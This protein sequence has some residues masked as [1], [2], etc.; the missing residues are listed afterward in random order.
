MH[1][2][3][4]RCITIL[5][6][7]VG[8]EFGGLSYARR[9]FR[10]APRVLNQI[11]AAAFELKS[12]ENSTRPNSFGLPRG[13]QDKR[14]SAASDGLA[15]RDVRA[16]WLQDGRGLVPCG[17]CGKSAGNPSPDRE[18]AES[19]GKGCPQAFHAARSSNET[20]TDPRQPAPHASLIDLA[21]LCG[22][23]FR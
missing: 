9:F 6:L 21:G 8:D 12:V 16:E 1:S 2:P 4:L 22:P 7:P 14:R 15:S 19:V 10:P 18:S 13:D 17:K 5:L 11:A 20:R 3:L 23:E